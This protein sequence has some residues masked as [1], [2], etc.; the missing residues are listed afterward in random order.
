MKTQECQRNLHAIYI[1]RNQKSK[2]NI[3][4]ERWEPVVDIQTWII[5][6]EL[7]WLEKYNF[8][9]GSSLVI[10]IEKC[11]THRENWKFY[12]QSAYHLSLTYSALSFFMN[13]YID[14]ICSLAL[15]FSVTINCV[16]IFILYTLQ[17]FTGSLQGRITT[18]GDPCSHYRKWV[19]RI[20]HFA[21]LITFFPCFTNIY[22]N[23]C[24]HPCNVYIQETA[25]SY[26][27]VWRVALI[28]CN[29]YRIITG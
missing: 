8:K 4:W 22:L 18:Q 11:F 19:C 12:E 6:Y 5:S 17:S 26:Y 16:V 2:F 25:K 24:F 14:K 13:T 15:L 23:C 20:Q 21:V 10:N 28:P 9:L 7:T 1:E 27:R 29:L 3:A